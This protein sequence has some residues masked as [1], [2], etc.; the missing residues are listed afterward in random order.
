MEVRIQP[1]FAQAKAAG[2]LHFR[3]LAAGPS[4][5]KKTPPSLA[6]FKP[7]PN[8]DGRLAAICH[9]FG[10]TREKSAKY[11][12]IRPGRSNQPDLPKEGNET[13]AGQ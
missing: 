4:I 8:T 13:T 3:T 6:S 11:V 9:L 5:A 7:V 2:S 12:R 10:K 1:I